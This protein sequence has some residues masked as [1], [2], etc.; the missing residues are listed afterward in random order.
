MSYK[1]KNKKN[2]QVEKGKDKKRREKMMN[3]KQMKMRE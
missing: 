1:N 3:W 2:N